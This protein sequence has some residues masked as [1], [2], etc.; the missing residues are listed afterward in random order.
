MVTKTFDNLK[1][2]KQK[3]VYDAL[4][5]EFTTYALVD[6]QVARIIKRADIS[7][8]SFYT[9]FTDLNDAYKWVFSQVMRDVHVH[10]DLDS[11]V[12]MVQNQP[13]VYQFLQKYY[14]INEQFL[15]LHD[16]AFA[17]SLR[18]RLLREDASEAETK[19]WLAMQS[20]HGLMRNFF[21][22]PDRE[23][24]IKTTYKKINQLL[25]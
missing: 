24:E 7:R 6:A 17:Q 4:V 21:L 22:Y 8:G 11:I 2:I 1:A 14:Q 12:Q 16:K 25:S 20:A 3:Q 19:G 15:A 9:Y 13:K 5:E 23:S 10:R 18:P